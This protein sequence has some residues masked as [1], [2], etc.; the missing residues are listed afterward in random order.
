MKANGASCVVTAKKAGTAVIT[1]KAGK[2]SYKCTVTVKKASSSSSQKK[3][4]LK[5]Y[6]Q[7]LKS[8]YI[9]TDSI[10]YIPKRS[11]KFSLIYLDSDSVPELVLHF[12]GMEF[13]NPW[14]NGV[15][16]TYSNGKVKKLGELSM[17]DY[18]LR[19][20][21]KKG[22]LADRYLD[23]MSDGL[24]YSRLNKGKYQSNL[25]Y[26]AVKRYV[27]STKQTRATF[28][29]NTESNRQKYLKFK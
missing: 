4:A 6:E 14:Q 24:S 19:Y 10:D 13:D 20:Y 8:G 3:K 28:Y 26:S 12:D 29:K 16:Y 9:S 21:R 25:S 7:F 23:D 18:C 11:C 17:M 5:A 1:A 15:L 27:G 22:V 2:K